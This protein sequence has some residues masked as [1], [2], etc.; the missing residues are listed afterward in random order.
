MTSHLLK[1]TRNDQ[2]SGRCSSGVMCSVLIA[3]IWF[4]V[5]YVSLKVS[6]IV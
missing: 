3:F 6:D 1:G 5:V 4:E 2:M